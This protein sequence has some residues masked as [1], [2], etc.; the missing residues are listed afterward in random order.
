[1]FYQPVARALVGTLYDLLVAAGVVVCYYLFDLQA[2][3]LMAVSVPL[4][5]SV[6]LVDNLLKRACKV[7]YRP[8]SD[9]YSLL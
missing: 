7:E 2:A 4:F 8:M 6:F 5:L 3:L 9:D 1:M